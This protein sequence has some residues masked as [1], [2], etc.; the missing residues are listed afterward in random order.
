MRPTVQ[1]VTTGQPIGG[2]FDPND[3]LYRMPFIPLFCIGFPVIIYGG[4]ERLVKEYE[5]RTS[6]RVRALK[7][8]SKEKDFTS[9]HRVTSELRMQLFEMEGLLERYIRHLEE[10][11]SQSKVILNSEEKS[12]MFAIR[13]QIAKIGA[14]IA[15]KAS[16]ALGGTALFRGDVV[17]RMLRDM[18]IISSH[19]SHSYEDSM[20]AYGSTVYGFEGSLVW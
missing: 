13:G 19:A 2:N 15:L 20:A 6:T 9:S 10:W 3:R 5:K 8:M 12:M 4:A 7:G 14:D 1:Q 18:I 11:H 17:E 16:L